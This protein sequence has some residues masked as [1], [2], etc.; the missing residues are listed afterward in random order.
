[1]RAIAGC[2][3]LVSAV[4]MGL[5]IGLLAWF[6]LTDQDAVRL[7]DIAIPC[8]SMVVVGAVLIW[9]TRFPPHSR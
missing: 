2:M 1:M 8:V 5:G 7:Q 3:R 6:N 9:M 4:M